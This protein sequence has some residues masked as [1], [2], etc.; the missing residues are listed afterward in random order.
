MTW[1]RLKYVRSYI[2]MLNISS[3]NTFLE[4]KEMT[5]NFKKCMG[6]GQGLEILSC[7]S[8]INTWFWASTPWNRPK[9]SG[10]RVLTRAPKK[11]SKILANTLIERN[12]PGGVFY[13]LC[14][15]IKSRVRDITT[16]CSNATIASNRL[17]PG[18]GLRVFIETDSE[19]SRLDEKDFCSSLVT[20][21]RWLCRGAAWLSIECSL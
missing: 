15:L 21:S 10:F 20:K 8:A 5:L 12:P 11:L 19:A 13:L 3:K 14:S 17:P 4:E 6:R 16:R 7:L 18:G 1:S 2:L 9:S